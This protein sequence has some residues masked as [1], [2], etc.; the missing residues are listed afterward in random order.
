MSSPPLRPV[1]RSFKS[2]HCKQ[3]TTLNVCQSFT[4]ERR[5]LV[6]CTCSTH[7]LLR[8]ADNGWLLR[9]GVGTRLR[10]IGAQIINFT[11]IYSINMFCNHH[12]KLNEIWKLCIYLY[13]NDSNTLWTKWNGMNLLLYKIIYK[14]HSQLIVTWVVYDWVASNVNNLIYIIWSVWYFDLLLFRLK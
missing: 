6:L 14:L 4:C 5:R 2:K 12:L 11:I 7:Q 3:Q 8:C 10:E 9:C 13:C 1:Q